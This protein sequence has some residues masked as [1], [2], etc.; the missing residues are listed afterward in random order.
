MAKPF[1]LFQTTN[2]TFLKLKATVAGNIIEQEFSSNGIFKERNSMAQADATENPTTEATLKVRPEASFLEPVVGNM[3]GH[4]IRVTKNGAAAQEYRI[5]SQVEGYDYDTGELE[6][7]NVTL[8]REAIAT[9]QD[10]PLE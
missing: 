7:Y 10:S 8:K 3:V 1:Q 6:F 2:F 5:V 4:G 9:W